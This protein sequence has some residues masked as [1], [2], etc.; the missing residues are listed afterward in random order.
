MFEV[1]F[2]YGNHKKVKWKLYKI[3]QFSGKNKERKR[4]KI[5][6]FKSISNSRRSRV[7]Q[8]SH[9]PGQQL[10]IKEQ[11]KEEKKKIDSD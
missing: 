5:E 2:F 6:I 8:S 3:K 9:L 7:C 4:W 11:W 1:F 10:Q